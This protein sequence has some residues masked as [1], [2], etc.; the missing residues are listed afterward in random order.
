MIRSP[1]RSPIRSA[2]RGPLVRSVGRSLEQEAIDAAR[3][4]NAA[5]WYIPDS[6][7]GVYQDAAGTTP[8]TASSPIG[9]VNDQQYGPTNAALGSSALGFVASQS[10]TGNRPTVTT[11]ANGRRAM[12]F[13]GTS[14]YLDHA[15]TSLLP[16][17]HTV[18]M[19]LRT[20][21]SGGS[22]RVAHAVRSTSGNAIMGQMYY[23]S[24][25][26]PTYIDRYNGFETVNQA[27]SATNDPHTFSAVTNNPTSRRVWLNGGAG[28]ALATTTGT[29]TTDKASIGAAWQPTVSQFW[30]GFISLVCVSNTAMPDSDRIAI[31]RFGAY[32]AGVTTYT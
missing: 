10:L 9:R 32:L 14:A 27:F 20:S 2:N 24:G 23:P 11:L 15:I 13:N 3:R 12:S 4:N 31:E 26:V 5:L 17:S 30:Q 25:N 22:D 6:L 1:I 7:A 18:I 19:A 29:A 16:N 28:V 21:A 8:A